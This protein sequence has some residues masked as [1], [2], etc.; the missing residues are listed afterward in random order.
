MRS[1]FLK[2][3]WAITK[4]F[5]SVKK[6]LNNSKK[7]DI[8]TDTVVSLDLSKMDSSI[9]DSIKTVNSKIYNEEGKEIFNSDIK[10]TYDRVTI[11][12]D[13]LSK[14][15]TYYAIATITLQDLTTYSYIF[16]F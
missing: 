14:S 1:T 15:E 6:A 9:K 7:L 16:K 3:P 10:V 12:V 11:A 8:T 5:D 2:S 4:V 13:E